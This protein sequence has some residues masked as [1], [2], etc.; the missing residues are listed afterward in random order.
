MTLGD[1]QRQVQGAAEVNAQGDT[2]T[3]DVNATPVSSVC[4]RRINYRGHERGILVCYPDTDL[5]MAKEIME[6][7]GI[8]QLPVVTRGGERRQERG[9]TLLGLL[10]HDGIPNCL[11]EARK[12]VMALAAQS[13]QDKDDEILLSGH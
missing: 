1:L 3:L 12:Q 8:K 13:R 4:T 6:A 9:H 5:M 11:R 10:C 2:I 7:R